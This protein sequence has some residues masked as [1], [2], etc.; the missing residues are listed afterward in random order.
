MEQFRDDEIGD[1][2]KDGAP[3]FLDGWA[4]PISFIRWAPAASSPLASGSVG[5]NSPIQIADPNRYH[6]PFDPERVDANGFAMY[7]LIMSGGPD[8]TAGI[9]GTGTTVSTCWSAAVYSGVTS[10]TNLLSLTGTSGASPGTV[11][12]SSTSIGATLVISGV[13]CGAVDAAS[14]TAFS[15][16]ITNHNL[17]RK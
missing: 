6:D 1:Y 17:I 14:P 4:R 2:D 7:P 16:N 8:Q 12:A 13:P 3:E 15:D 9:W 11:I 5:I 10:G